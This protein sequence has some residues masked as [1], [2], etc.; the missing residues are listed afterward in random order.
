MYNWSK[1]HMYNMLGFF[2]ISLASQTML[3]YQ[4]DMNNKVMCDGG[5]LK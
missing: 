1:M 4:P 5:I 3:G 2:C